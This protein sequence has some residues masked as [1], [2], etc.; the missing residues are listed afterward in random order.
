VICLVM[1]YPGSDK[2]GATRASL[3][4]IL[5]S[6]KMDITSYIFHRDRLDKQTWLETIS[7]VLSK[8]MCL[9]CQMAQSFCLLTDS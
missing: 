3:S 2:T 7:R 6:N 1:C 5:P 4:F 9:W 8:I